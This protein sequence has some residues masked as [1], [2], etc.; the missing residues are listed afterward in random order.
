MPKPTF[1]NLPERKRDPL[2]EALL[3]EFAARGYRHA[4]LDRI[5]KAG[6][7]S[8]GSLY[9]YFPNKADMYRWLLTEEVPRRKMAAM[10]ATPLDPGADLFETL[11]VWF[12][13]GLQLFVREPRLAQLGAVLMHP[14]SEP[15]IRA[16]HQETR[17]QSH[18]YLR[19]MV[20]AAM[21]KG[22]V[23]R[24]LDVDLV[25]V[26]VSK[27]MGSGLSETLLLRIGADA[28]ELAADPSVAARLAQED[29]A[30]LVHQAAE[31]L[32]RAVGVTSARR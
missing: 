23:R 15:E 26:L 21:D 14:T 7:V 18:A 32:R 17:R 4:S 6:G 27:V 20:T 16:L 25:A 1:F 11:E 10:Q 31:V 5:A 12:L 29:L 9:Q 8:K 19:T 22:E 2:V 13:A 3:N 24:D 30:G 28:T